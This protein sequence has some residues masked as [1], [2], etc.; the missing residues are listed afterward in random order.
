M[1]KDDEKPKPLPDSD[2]DSDCEDGDS[3]WGVKV[4]RYNGLMDKKGPGMDL[5][6]RRS[7]AETV[8][9][10]LIVSYIEEKRTVPYEAVVL[11]I[12]AGERRRLQQKI[13]TDF[14]WVRFSNGDTL[15]I[16]DEDDWDWQ[17]RR[18]APRA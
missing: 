1:G 4:A 6:G 2:S 3:K 11:E 13:G 12:S 10:V 16:T 8:G 18:A 14:M 15:P 7:H 5:R 17:Q 9:A